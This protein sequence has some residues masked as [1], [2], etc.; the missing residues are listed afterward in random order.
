[1]NTLIAAA[2]VLSGSLVA[3]AQTVRYTVT[4]LG[5]LGSFTSKANAISPSGTIVGT[6]N[7]PESGYEL[8]VVFG[9][10]GSVFPLTGEGVS[11]AVASGVNDHGVIVGMTDSFGLHGFVFDTCWLIDLGT[12]MG[13]WVSEANAVS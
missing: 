11:G 7:T 2:A 4:D 1:M 9:G 13:G 5:S 12:P 10:E 8:A 3:S 6:A